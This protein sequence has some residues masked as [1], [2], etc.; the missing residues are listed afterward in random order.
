MRLM[1]L[2]F[3]F[4]FAL[5]GQE[6]YLVKNNLKGN[7]KTIEYLNCEIP[8][9]YKP[10]TKPSYY[11]DS[12]TIS[13]GNIVNRFIFDNLN[14]L[15]DSWEY[16]YDE[17]GRK[18]S[19]VSVRFSRKGDTSSC[20]VNLYKYSQN[21]F[22][23][24]EISQCCLEVLL[25]CFSQGITETYYNKSGVR[26]GEIS[27]PPEGEAIF[28]RKPYYDESLRTLFFIRENSKRKSIT[29]FNG[30]GKRIESLVFLEGH[31]IKRWSYKYSKDGKIIE[32]TAYYDD[33]P[34]QNNKYG[35][36]WKWEIFYDVSGNPVE[37]IGANDSGDVE[38]TQLLYEFDDVGNWVSRRKLVNG[39]FVE[40]LMRIIEYE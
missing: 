29:R 31:L 7:I 27:I 13:N 1:F 23:E 8:P 39:E 24:K 36:V 14:N 15:I 33:A 40:D 26:I 34:H 28:V 37:I 22:L 5:L 30:L 32:R 3:V 2:C 16:K 10:N 19:M 18:N 4:P 9:D 35:G 6:N 11:R 25:E 21:G 20:H 17:L 38:H 12:I